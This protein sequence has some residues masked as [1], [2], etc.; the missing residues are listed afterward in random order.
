MNKRMFNVQ[1]N[2]GEICNITEVDPDDID[3]EAVVIDCSATPRRKNR[4][5]ISVIDY[6]TGKVSK[7]P[8]WKILLEQKLVGV[9]LIVIGI[10]G[11]WMDPVN[12]GIL[13][14]AFGALGLWL[15]FTKRV[16][17][18]LFKPFE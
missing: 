18:F 3:H 16:D 2:A 17:M 15:L 8:V 7:V 14:L 1:L 12:G 9:L 13:T 11:G 10:W 6:G 5:S 4:R